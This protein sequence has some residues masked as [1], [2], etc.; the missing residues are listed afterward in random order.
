MAIVGVDFT[1][2]CLSNARVIKFCRNG[3]DEVIISGAYPNGSCVFFG[4]PNNNYE[5]RCKNI[6]GVYNLTISRS[7]NI[8][9]IHD[10]TWQCSAPLQIK[11]S[12]VIKLYV[13]GE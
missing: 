4:K 8:D 10:S 5:Y 2:T 9:S 1:F 3:E 7:F 12:E 6:T 13:N 11:N